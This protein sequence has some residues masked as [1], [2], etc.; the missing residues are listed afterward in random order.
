MIKNITKIKHKNQNNMILTDNQFQEPHMLK[1]IWIMED[2][3]LIP[4]SNP[5][6]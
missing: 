4:K 2:C 3:Q 6:L 5:K 1:I